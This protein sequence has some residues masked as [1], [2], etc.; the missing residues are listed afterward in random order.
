MYSTRTVQGLDRSASSIN[1]YRLHVLDQRSIHVLKE[2]LIT[3]SP[4]SSSPPARLHHGHAACTPM[5]HRSA[6]FTGARCRSRHESDFVDFIETQPSCLY[7]TPVSPLCRLHRSLAVRA[8]APVSSAW[9]YIEPVFRRIQICA[10]EHDRDVREARSL[11]SSHG[12]CQLQA[13][14]LPW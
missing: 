10:D 5:S 6:D 13:H 8:A 11:T 1:I 2:A 12:C 9:T 4:S 3:S 7:C 14:S